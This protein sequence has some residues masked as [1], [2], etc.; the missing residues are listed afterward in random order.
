MVPNIKD[1]A[2]FIVVCTNKESIDGDVVTQ[3]RVGNQAFATYEV[4]TRM[5]SLVSES[6]APF[7][8][9]VVASIRAF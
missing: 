3:Q 2:A 9:A 4:F 1:M 5:P 6:E 7:I 8:N